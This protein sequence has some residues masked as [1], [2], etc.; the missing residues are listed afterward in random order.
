MERKR[1]FVV[2]PRKDDDDEAWVEWIEQSEVTRFL[3]EGLC[4]MTRLGI[5][6]SVG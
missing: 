3:Y 2:P 6:R 1:R 4:L 5:D